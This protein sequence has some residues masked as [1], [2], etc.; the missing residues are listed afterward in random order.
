MFM[1]LINVTAQCLLTS[2]FRSQS[3]PL[4]V[5]L[6]VLLEFA[7]VILKN[8][9]TK[10]LFYFDNVRNLPLTSHWDEGLAFVPVLHAAVHTFPSLPHRFPSSFD[11]ACRKIHH[12]LRVTT[13]ETTCF[14]VNYE[15]VL[16]YHTDGKR[17]PD[18]QDV[19]M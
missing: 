15:T 9:F 16:P 5:V 3:Q 4:A 18:F 13:K 17:Q 12:H 10:L 19:K 8:L 14:Q 1:R 11:A 2:R 7:A 6:V